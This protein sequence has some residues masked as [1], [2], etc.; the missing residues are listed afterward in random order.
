MITENQ[1]KILTCPEDFFKTAKK[2]FQVASP[3][4]QY[5]FT[6]QKKSG[7]EYFTVKKTLRDQKNKFSRF[8]FQ[9][10][11]TCE[12]SCISALRRIGYFVDLEKNG[13]H[14]FLLSGLSQKL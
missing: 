5:D 2:L 12:N 6:K 10:S 1:L 7:I 3:K 4:Y 9:Y 8:P 14:W 13:C 11:F